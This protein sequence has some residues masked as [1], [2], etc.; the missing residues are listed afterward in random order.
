[1]TLSFAHALQQMARGK[2]CV[3][4]EDWHYRIVSRS[5]RWNNADY[6]SA[7]L[8]SRCGK[9]GK[10]DDAVQLVNTLLNREFVI[11]DS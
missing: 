4:G 1:M 5:D 7:I 6:V 3:D 9:D 2:I 11:L 10:W 8:Q